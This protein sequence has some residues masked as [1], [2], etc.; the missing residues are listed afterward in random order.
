MGTGK[1]LCCDVVNYRNSLLSSLCP[2][3]EAI[4]IKYNFCESIYIIYYNVCTCMC[5]LFTE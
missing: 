2:N 4:L 1:G 3:P 5:V